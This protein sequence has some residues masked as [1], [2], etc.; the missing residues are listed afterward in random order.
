MVETGSF[1]A[2]LALNA[3]NRKLGWRER[4]DG[5][6][7]RSRT[8]LGGFAIRYITA[9]LTRHLRVEQD[10]ERETRLELATLTLARLCSTN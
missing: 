3:K 9:L 7:F 8:G 10:L 6:A 1:G 4:E 2:P 5:G